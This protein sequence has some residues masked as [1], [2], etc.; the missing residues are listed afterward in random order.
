[1]TF[2]AEI[3]LF[4]VIELLLCHRAWLKPFRE[5]REVLGRINVQKLIWHGPLG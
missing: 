3:Y 1:M 2:L 5:P 4:I